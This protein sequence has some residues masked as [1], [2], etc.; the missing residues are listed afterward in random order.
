MASG[1]K[2]TKLDS[3]TRNFNDDCTLQYLFK[4]MLPTLHN[5]KPICSVV[6]LA[7]GH[8]G[9]CP[10][11]CFGSSVHSTASANLAVKILK[12]TEEKHVLHFRLSR[13]K[14]ATTYENRLKQS[15]NPKKIP[16]REGDEKFILC[17]PSPH[18]LA[19]PLNM[20]AVKRMCV[21]CEG[22]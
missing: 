14:H 2:K 17:S 6:S 3:E 15:V 5:F 21:G 1:A 12:I 8:W 22:V 7:I 9:T 10:S 18:F 19:T 4:L 11:S 13:Q 16:G 20:S